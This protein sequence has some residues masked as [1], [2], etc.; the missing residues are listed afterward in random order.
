MTHSDT[1]LATESADATARYERHV[2]PYIAKLLRLLAID[3]VYT[4]AEGDTLVDA[5]GR[6]VLDLLGG[7]GSTLL[8]HNHPRLVRTLCDAYAAGVPTNVQGSVRERAAR[9]AERL[10]GLLRTALPA[11][12]G[13]IIHFS[14][15]GTEAVEAAIKHALMEHR[16][17]RKRWTTTTDKLLLECLDQRP[18]DPSI[19]PLRALKEAVERQAPVLLAVQGSYHGKAAGAL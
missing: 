18:D 3:R 11:S 16:A 15:T 2:K 1:T 14:S 19:A 5:D 17:R 8:G 10:G 4:R 7:Y 12:D 13:H 6:E 9:L